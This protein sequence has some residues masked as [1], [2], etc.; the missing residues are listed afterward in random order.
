MNGLLKFGLQSCPWIL[1]QQKCSM[2]I[3]GGEGTFLQNIYLFFKLFSGR[4]HSDRCLLVL[5]TMLAA[6][7][8]MSE[9]HT[10]ENK[11]QSTSSTLRS[12]KYWPFKKC[13]FFFLTSQPQFLSL[14]FIINSHVTTYI[15]KCCIIPNGEFICR[16]NWLTLKTPGNQCVFCPTCFVF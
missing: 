2:K 6:F 8:A 16:Q 15:T 12:V 4:L 14:F 13:K 10:A 1:T 9:Y 11:R 7:K 5:K 3:G